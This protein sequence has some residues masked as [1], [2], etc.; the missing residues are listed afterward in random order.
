MIISFIAKLARSIVT[1]VIVKLDTL[2]AVS[3]LNPYNN[4]VG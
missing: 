3:I 4:K 1:H 2:G